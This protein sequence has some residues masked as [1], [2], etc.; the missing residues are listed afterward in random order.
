MFAWPCLNACGSVF[1]CPN[2]PVASI[3]C[4]T[5]LVPAIP[6]SKSQVMPA[7][8]RLHV[9][10]VCLPVSANLHV[11]VCMF[12][13]PW[14]HL[15]MSTCM[16]KLAC[17][18]VHA[19]ILACRMPIPACLHARISADMSASLQSAWLHGCMSMSACLHGCM[20]MSAWLR[21]HAKM[22]MLASR[23]GHGHSGLQTLDFFYPKA[24]RVHAH[25]SMSMSATVPVSKPSI[26]MTYNHGSFTPGSSSKRTSPT[27]VMILDMIDP[28][29]MAFPGV[30]TLYQYDMGVSVKWHMLGPKSSWFT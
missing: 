25:M 28:K 5:L 24:N 15:C 13:S 29:I 11:H 18:H 6:T 30:R 4:A 3:F 22:D 10:H 16:S 12:M 1:A 7:Y 9:L 21:V 19:L 14:L 20:S 27:A 23:H 8:P 17:L 2:V 26:W